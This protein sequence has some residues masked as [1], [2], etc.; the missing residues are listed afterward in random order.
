MSMYSPGAREK[1]TGTTTKTVRLGTLLMRSGCVKSDGFQW[2]LDT[3]KRTD[4]P[5]GA[6]L[7]REN[8][9]QRNE[10]SY[11]LYL[12]SL[13]S[14]GKLTTTQAIEVLQQCHGNPNLNAED[15][16]SSLGYHRSDEPEGGLGPLL[17]QAGWLNT[18]LYENL[19]SSGQLAVSLLIKGNLS[20]R[21]IDEA[22]KALI[23]IN[24]HG[25]SLEKAASALSRLRLGEES[26]GERLVKDGAMQK[27][28]IKLFLGELFHEAAIIPE[29]DLLAAVEASISKNAF[30]GKELVSRGLITTETMQAALQLQ[31][32]VMREVLNRSQAA[33]IL[34]DA[35]RRKVSLETA[36]RAASLFDEPTE[37]IAA[38]LDLLRLSGALSYQDMQDARENWVNQFGC[39]AG[40]LASGKVTRTLLAAALSLEE[41]IQQRQATKDF[42]VMTLSVCYRSGCTLSEALNEGGYADAP[43]VKEEIVS[44]AAISEVVPREEIDQL[45]TQLINEKRVS[46]YLKIAGVLG[47]AALV[48][49]LGH[50]FVPQQVQMFVPFIVLAVVAIWL[51]YSLTQ[52]IDSK[53][54]LEEMDDMRINVAVRTK[55]RP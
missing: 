32:L 34:R 7:I 49:Y 21:R 25:I 37:R 38:V 52:S 15:V 4:Q 16:L 29:M 2:A 23:Y 14:Q 43:T 12:Q 54:S 31:E 51:F 42:C 5:I 9:L 48:W 11:A 24:R 20:Y 35:T 27:N 46:I 3:A 26:V 33:T 1:T 19:K 55:T 30:L 39:F 50:N 40:L 45:R 47:T 28:S 13:I 53:K 41:R 8:L 36:M 6:V 18:A 10:L 17:V 22:F 44:I